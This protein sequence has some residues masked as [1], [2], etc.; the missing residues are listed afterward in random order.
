MHQ[1]PCFV[2]LF[3]NSKSRFHRHPRLHYWAE[4]TAIF[5]IQ[6]TTKPTSSMGWTNATSF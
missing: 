6:S 4:G 1:N 5:E 2:G 3:G